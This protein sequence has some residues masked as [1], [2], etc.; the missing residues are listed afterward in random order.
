MSS[1]VPTQGRG[2]LFIVSAPSGAGKTSLCK[3]I[4]DIF[5]NLRQSVSFTT[6]PMRPGERE[7][8]DYFFVDSET[9][10]DMVAHGAFAEWA[11]VHGNRY[12]TAIQAL[13]QWRDAGCN[14]L[15]D[16]DTQ[17]AQQLRES[18]GQ[19]VFIFI[20]PPDFDEL[21]RRLE[22]R[23]TD[24]AQVIERRISNA[25]EEIRQS[26]HYDYIIVNDDFE[27]ALSQMKAI[28]VAEDCRAQKMLHDVATR[29][30]LNP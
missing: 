13:E 2:T 22:G 28:I 10:D 11:E 24:S 21:R 18:Y 23:G 17:G 3:R 29:F 25:R 16:I 14:V 8:V 4:I 9:F 30:H 5:P 12:G 27:T 15:L 20:L 19:G 6:R 26:I 1:N 7:G